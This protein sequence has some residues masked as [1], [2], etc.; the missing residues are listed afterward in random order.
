MKFI[1][2]TMACDKSKVSI[3]IDKL[4][5]I[6]EVTEVAKRSFTDQKSTVWV[7][8][9]GPDRCYISIIESRTEILTKIKEAI[10]AD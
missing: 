7:S 1:E 6:R 5:Y 2:L 9:L 3:N 4:A 10:D 8:G